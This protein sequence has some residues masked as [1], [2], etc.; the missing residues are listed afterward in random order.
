MNK[1]ICV[2][3]EKFYI[4]NHNNVIFYV[5]SYEDWAKPVYDSFK[6]YVNNEVGKN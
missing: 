5:M 2:S 3:A 1:W 6:K 4:T